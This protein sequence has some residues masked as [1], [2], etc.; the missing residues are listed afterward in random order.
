MSKETDFYIYLIERYAESKGKTA[1]QVLQLWDSLNLT[2]FIYKFKRLSRKTA[3]T[4][5][6][7]IFQGHKNKQFTTNLLQIR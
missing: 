2:D 5:G 3:K 4:K 6:F 7:L 1:A